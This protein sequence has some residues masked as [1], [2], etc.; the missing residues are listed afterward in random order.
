MGAER[1]RPCSLVYKLRPGSGMRS[2]ACVI[3]RG[4]ATQV[5]PVRVLRWSPG[6]FQRRWIV[7]RRDEDEALSCLVGPLKKR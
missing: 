2:E 3:S 5:V 7:R 6:P 4:R 1:V